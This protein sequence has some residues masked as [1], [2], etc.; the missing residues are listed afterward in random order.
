MNNPG[1]LALILILSIA[2]T[3]NIMNIQALK[4]ID[5][6]TYYYAFVCTDYCGLKT[7]DATYLDA[8]IF[9]EYQ[10]RENNIISFYTYYN[11][12]TL[13]NRSYSNDYGVF[14][15]TEHYFSES[16]KNN[17]TGTLAWQWVGTSFPG[18][19]EVTIPY[20]FLAHDLVKQESEYPIELSDGKT[21]T[22]FEYTGDWKYEYEESNSTITV[23]SNIKTFYDVESGL[24][25]RID[26][27]M[28]AYHESDE[29]GSKVP[30]VDSVGSLKMTYVEQASSY[31]TTY[32]IITIT[33]L[34]I[35]IL[36]RKRS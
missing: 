35:V 23:V 15:I 2:F 8:D 18:N 36:S 28:V 29:L 30:I 14:N 33:S 34:L 22:T 25:I 11:S 1:K 24:I 3:T 16:R 9:I 31:K 17:K 4:L 5:G 13:I 26:L 6:K 27:E 19:I 10:G 12:T 21:I 32:P 7:W 20:F